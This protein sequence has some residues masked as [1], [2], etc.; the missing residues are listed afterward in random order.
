[1]WIIELAVVF[2]MSRS[3]TRTIPWYSIFR[4]ESTSAGGSWTFVWILFT[5]EAKFTREAVLNSL[6]SHVWADENL[7]AARP[8]GI[9]KRYSLNICAGFLDGYV[10]GPYL[11]PPNVTCAMYLRYL[12]GVLHGLLEYVPLHVRQNI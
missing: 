6:N 4:H 7:H 11:L 8:Y 1:M 12:E 2:C 10:I 3:Y 5:D 9:Q